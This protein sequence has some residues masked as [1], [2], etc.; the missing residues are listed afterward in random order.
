M[1][2]RTDLGRAAKLRCAVVRRRASAEGDALIFAVGA[3]LGVAERG[4]REERGW[5]GPSVDLEKAVEEE[6]PVR[7]GVKGGRVE[8]FVVGGEWSEGSVR[9]CTGLARC[10]WRRCL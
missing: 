7:S 6:E 4:R 5:P 2:E 10:R 3:R 1:V 9:R 8:D